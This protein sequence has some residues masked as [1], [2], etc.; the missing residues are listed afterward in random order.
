MP[1]TLSQATDRDSGENAVID[2]KVA[3]VKYENA[4]SQNETVRTIF[5][6]VTTQQKDRYVGIIQ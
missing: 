3:E 2:F 5:E 1:A 4:Y 6:A